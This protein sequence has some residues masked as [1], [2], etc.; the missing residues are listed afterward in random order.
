MYT[1]KKGQKVWYLTAS[2]DKDPPSAARI[3]QRERFRLAQEAWQSLTT[4]E[5]EN[6]E[7]ACRRTS[8]C[9]TGQNLYI[10][11]ALKDQNG[12]VQAIAKATGIPLPTVVYVPK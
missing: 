6:L 9:L 4:E 10:S 11:A 12:S 8:L 7:E 1:T 2:P 5:K 3:R